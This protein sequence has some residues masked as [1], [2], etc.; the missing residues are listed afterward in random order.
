M[1][2]HGVYCGANPIKK[3]ADVARC[4]VMFGHTHERGVRSFKN[5]DGT[6][7]GFN[8]PCL[9]NTQPKYM[10]GRPHNWS[11]GFSTIQ[12]TDEAFYV[13]QFTIHDGVLLDAHGRNI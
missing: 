11:V 6:F 8:N 7:M 4:S 12:V 9:C 1:L 10:E 13:N 3:H 5:V 2:T